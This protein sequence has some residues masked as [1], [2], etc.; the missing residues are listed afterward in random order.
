MKN[1]VGGMFSIQAIVIFLVL[2]TGLLA[3]S[4]NY[5]K[6]FKV[7]NEFRRIIEEFEG[8]TEGASVKIDDM[9]DKYKY[10]VSNASTYVDLCNKME[11]YKAYH[12]TTKDNNNVVFCVKCDLANVEGNKQGNLKYKGAYYTVTTFVNID[13]PLINKIFPQAAG[14][15]RVKGQTSL[16][17]SS[18]N[19]SELCRYF[20]TE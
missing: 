15:L 10:H 14:F 11:G 17:Y 19:N 16:I 6:A 9:A 20:K 1:A 3:F 12:S 7:K 13:I 5:T 2:A 4:V 18:G 8:L